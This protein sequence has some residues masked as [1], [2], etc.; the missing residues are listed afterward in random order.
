MGDK[1]GV[2][3]AQLHA[4]IKNLDRSAEEMTRATTALRGASAQDL[5]SRAIDKAGKGFQD[6][7]EHGIGKIAEATEK[8]TKALAETTKDYEHTER[9]VHQLFPAGGS[10]G[11]AAPARE[12][13]I[14]RGL[15]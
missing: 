3:F 12:S 7:W 11:Q 8:M 2:N 10:G 5:G 9:A 6:R 14:T 1:L 4:L 13:A 15:G